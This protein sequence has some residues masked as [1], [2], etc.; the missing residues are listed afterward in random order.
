M[1]ATV[2]LATSLLVTAV[3]VLRAR[4]RTPAVTPADMPAATP[5]ARPAASLP[6]GPA[7]APRE[8]T[9]A[10]PAPT[11]D[12]RLEAAAAQATDRLWKLA[13]A[14]PT[15]T[16]S[17]PEIYRKVR[18]NVLAKLQVDTLD[19]DCFPRRPALL[20][21]LLR[22]VDDPQ[23][24]S[25]RI[26]RII[27][28]DPVLTADVLRL[29][30]SALYRTTAAPVETIPRAI[31]VCGIDALRA[32]L[33]AALLRPVFRA[34]RRNFPRFPRILWDRT[35]RAARAAELY[36][37]ATAPQDRFEGQMAVLLGALGP[38][39]VYGAVL[40][41]YSRNAHFL[42]NAALCVDLIGAMGPAMAR[43]IACDWQASPRL[44]AA[45]EDSNQDF[46]TTAR[47]VGELLGTLAFLESQTV[48]TGGQRRDMIALAGID[49][50]L[51]EDIGRALARPA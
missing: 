28:H 5:A 49:G 32:M 22:A 35:E 48:I 43:R 39:V 8:E 29:A 15:Q 20:P 36:A 12:G 27:A 11:D 26:A 7:A 2:L 50:A 51:A 6:A 9:G 13:F 4:A 18:D 31:V 47:R 41:V 3:W 25:E 37:M 14:A 30:N 1:Y 44:V 19:P 10:A 40:D 21:Q 42:P 16:Q 38:L 24:A 23:A 34:T 46:L 33:A 45:L 17:S